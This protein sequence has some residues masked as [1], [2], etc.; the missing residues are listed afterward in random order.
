V[1][2]YQ[3]SWGKI[4][5]ARW[6]ALSVLDGPYL[7][8]GCSSG[9]YVRL[10]AS[11]GAVASGFD[12]EASPNWSLA[13]ELFTVG[14][15]QSI[16]FPENSFET[17]FSFEVLEHLEDPE[18]ALKEMKRVSSRNVLV[19]VPDCEVPAVFRNSGLTYNHFSD[20]THVQFFTEKSL[21]ELFR[22]AGMEMVWIKK[23]N[24][25]SPD[26]LHYTSQG[27]PKALVSILSRVARLNPLAIKYH[28][29]L[30]ALGVTTAR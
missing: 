9:D 6:N 3:K 5:E 28:M 22:S 25:V 21:G 15:A 19:T 26:L 11:E 20:P 4:V 29:T 1:Q 16:P 8:A 27:F 17:V 18:K 23:I 12:I 14:S 30:M 24:R 10:L 13:P 7:D 2:A